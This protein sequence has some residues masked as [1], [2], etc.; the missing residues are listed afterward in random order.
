MIPIEVLQRIAA[1][2]Q[3]VSTETIDVYAELAHGGVDIM[4]Q[5]D[6]LIVRCQ[7]AWDSL[8]TDREAVDRAFGLVIAKLQSEDA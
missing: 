8:A 4:G 2:C 5:K 6:D 3:Q 7:I 1:L